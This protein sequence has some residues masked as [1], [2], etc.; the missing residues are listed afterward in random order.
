MVTVSRPPRLLG[1][2]WCWSR[3]GPGII[4]RWHN[5][6]MAIAAPPLTVALL[7]TAPAISRA[8]RRDILG[9]GFFIGESP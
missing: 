3:L 4:G 9:L 1:T 8:R 7:A 2:G 6:Q 5:G